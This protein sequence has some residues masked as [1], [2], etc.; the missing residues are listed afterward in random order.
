[1]N[2]RNFDCKRKYDPKRSTA[3]K[4]QKTYCSEDC[5]KAVQYRRR[6][7]RHREEEARANRV[8]PS[9]VIRTSATR[10]GVPEQ[11]SQPNVEGLKGQRAGQ[12]ES[13]PHTT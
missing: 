11:S 6:I 13:N 8:A 4:Q 9:P 3:L 2:C 10:T 1:M 7:W 5:R 12:P